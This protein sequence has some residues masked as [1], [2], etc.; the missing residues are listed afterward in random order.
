M[1]KLTHLRNL[2]IRTLL[3]VVLGSTGC[4][5]AVVSTISVVSAW[6]E[7]VASRRVTHIAAAGKDLLRMYEAARVERGNTI[8]ILAAAD[9]V[10][11]DFAQATAKRRQEVEEAYQWVT[12]ALARI[13]LPTLVPLQGALK[14]SHATVEA[15]RPRAES[16]ARQAKG[17]RPATL[18]A[19]WDVGAN[20]MLENIL[21]LSA[22]LDAAMKQGD[23]RLDHLVSLKQAA[24]SAR[25]SASG[26]ILMVAG[27]LAGDR[28]LPV[29]LQVREGEARGRTAAAWEI[30]AEMAK[31]EDVPASVKDAVAQANEGYFAKNG[32]RKEVIKA[33][34]Q[35]DALDLTAANW[36]STLAMQV[37]SLGAVGAEAMAAAVAR[38]E[39]E[40]SRATVEL[41]AS[42]LGLVFV[43]GFVGFGL[44]IVSRRVSIPIGGLTEA[45][46][47]FAD[48][49]YDAPLVEIGRQDELGRMR[50]ALVVLAENGRKGIEAQRLRAEQ[51][52]Q[53]AERAAQVEALCHGFDEHVR[54]SL[55]DA[56]EATSRLGTAAQ[57]MAGAAGQA[58]DE[59]QV[60]A[61]A[62]EEASSG[63][64]TVASATEELSSSIVE[65]SRQT[66]QSTGIAAQAVAKAQETDQAINGLAV[67][68]DKIGEIVSLISGIAGQTNLLAL[69]A[70]IEAARA[71]D[72][73]KGFAV[74]AGEVKTLA[75]QTAK[76]T[77]EIGNQVADIQAMT[78]QAVEGV[79]AIG[80]V[81]KEMSAIAT[82]IASAIEEQGAATQEIARNVS[83]VSTAARTITAGTSGLAGM[84]AQSNEAALQVK[85]A[86]AS[87]VEQ[88]ASLRG[89]VARFLED[90]RAA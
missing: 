55:A 26:P 86:T 48:Q 14:D 1:A 50:A 56:S 18:L 77:E 59:S 8:S 58:A 32:Y 89:E 33:L 13:D 22:A 68:S 29:E 12:A 78:Q 28:K 85:T 64:S 46:G 34:A 3:S 23:A 41:V 9:P 79:R 42:S 15:L 90:L 65:I 54:R 43:C 84:A 82:G 61:S 75:N 7:S 21:S 57:A 31:L 40:A 4:I 2:S 47:Q 66:A 16:A 36:L 87:M 74:V 80:S 70:T 81:I 24:L 72:A 6:G 51:Q 27:V 52:R 53:L 17:E 76:A 38:A 20:K 5:L 45:I 60:V 11:A 71:G 35:G 67:A 63:I 83:E 69:N 88:T 39:A 10:A 49:H 19:E 37:G 44:F 62:S 25:I 73:G 30:V